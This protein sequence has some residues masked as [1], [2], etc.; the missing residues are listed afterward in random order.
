MNDIRVSPLSHTFTDGQIHPW[1]T[2]NGEWEMITTEDNLYHIGQQVEEPTQEELSNAVS[3]LRN[4]LSV[5]HHVTQKV[6]LTKSTVARAAQKYVL[7]LAAHLTADYFVQYVA[8]DH[9][10]QIS[11]PRLQLS[12]AHSTRMRP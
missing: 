10:V 3:H 11:H 4:A 6:G 9:D 1:V 12:L 5:L 8:Q 7:I 2:L